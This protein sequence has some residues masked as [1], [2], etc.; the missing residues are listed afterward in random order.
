[1]HWVVGKEGAQYAFETFLN[2]II[3]NGIFDI[4]KYEIGCLSEQPMLFAAT[5]QRHRKY[6]QWDIFTALHGC[7]FGRLTQFYTS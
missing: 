5:V 1:M 7:L 6:G 3:T 2:G 4:Y